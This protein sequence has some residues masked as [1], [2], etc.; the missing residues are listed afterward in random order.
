MAVSTGALGLR[1]ADTRAACRA[2]V[3]EVHQGI[4]DTVEKHTVQVRFRVDEK[5]RIPYAR[6]EYRLIEILEGVCQSV[7]VCTALATCGSA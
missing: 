5:I 4:D 1:P 2:I 3:D 7:E 6:T